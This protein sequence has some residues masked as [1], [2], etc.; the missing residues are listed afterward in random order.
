MVDILLTTI[1][2]RYRHTAYGLRCLHANLGDLA[3]RAAILEFDLERTPTEMA[4]AILARQPRM[5]GIGVYIW[6]AEPTHKLVQI[7]KRLRPD[8]VLVLGGPEISHETSDQP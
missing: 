3:H 1:H 8:M 4:E 6:N 7:L 5:V 2:A